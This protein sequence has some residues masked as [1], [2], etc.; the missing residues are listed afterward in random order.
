MNLVFGLIDVS[1]NLLIGV[2]EVGS[3]VVCEGMVWCWFGDLFIYV[4]ILLKL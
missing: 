1:E 3:G 2:F 4:S